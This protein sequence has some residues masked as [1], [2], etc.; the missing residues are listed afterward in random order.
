MQGFR[1]L[2]APVSSVGL[3]QGFRDGPR[4]YTQVVG[5]RHKAPPAA[6]MQAASLDHAAAQARLLAPCA[7]PKASPNTIT[8]VSALHG[9][10]GSAMTT[11]V[12]EA[13]VATARQS[14]LSRATS[15]LGAPRHHV[16]HVVAGTHVLI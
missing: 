7:L 10:G 9:L 4:P 2:G 11:P 6:M 16:A 14:A 3:Q 1:G 12:V 15:A 8:A 5:V 13:M